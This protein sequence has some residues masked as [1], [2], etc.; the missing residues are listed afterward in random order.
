M[1]YVETLASALRKVSTVRVDKTEIHDKLMQMATAIY[2]CPVR[3]K[4]GRDLPTVI[5]CCSNIV[6]EYAIV[7]ALTSLDM[8]SQL[9]PHQWQ[10]NNKETYKYDVEH[11]ADNRKYLIEFK[12]MAGAWFSMQDDQLKT[13]KKHAQEL[14][15]LV[16]AYIDEYPD[17]YT[18]IFS[19]VINP[20]TFEH[21]WTPSNFT[22]AAR[23]SAHYYSH[24]IAKKRSDC[25][26]VQVL[27]TRT[28]EYYDNLNFVIEDYND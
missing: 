7:K 28:K 5:K 4:Q 12:R 15:A 8:C 2:E 25:S 19:L 18:V 24:H 17:H 20:K 6:G 11:H 10:V 14:D 16:T 3:N 21:Y 23:K 1:N 26:L 13:F 27:T 22:K 9:N